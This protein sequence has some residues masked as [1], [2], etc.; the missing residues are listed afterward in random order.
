M[1]AR[2]IFR[3]LRGAVGNAMVWGAGWAALAY[4]VCA[5]LHVA[6]VMPSPTWWLDGIMVA[7]RFGIVGAI[8]GGA[9][10]AVVGLGFR[11]QRLAEIGWVRFGLGGGLATGVFL[12]TFLSV[13]RVL[14]GDTVL[15]PAQFLS[16]GLVG[17]AFGGIV[18]AAS[19]RLAQHAETAA[20]P[21][22]GAETLGH[23]TAG[24]PFSAVPPRDA[25]R[26]APSHRSGDGPTG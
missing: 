14:T 24:D 17:M 19:L 1:D 10:S 16:N 2:S 8:A 22:S 6:G 18:A 12:P 25:R 11:G 9:F 21:R 23:L 26:A 7:G 15:S 13:M 4:G 5:A 20:V 3:R